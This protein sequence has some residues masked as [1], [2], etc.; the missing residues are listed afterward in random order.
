MTF[1]NDADKNILLFSINSTGALTPTSEI[2]NSL[3]SKLLY[4]IKRELVQITESNYESVLIKGE[5]STSPVKDVKLIIETVSEERVS[6]RKCIM[7]IF[8]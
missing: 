5:L 1:L 3:K 7:S 8:I 6:I 2:P 4:F